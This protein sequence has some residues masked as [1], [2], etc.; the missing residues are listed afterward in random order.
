[1]LRV[2]TGLAKGKRLVCP[3]G[4]VTRPP[5]DFL[6][7]AV[8][9]ILGPR[10]VDASVLD[11]FAGCGAFGIEALS[12]GATICQFVER[13]REALEALRRNL[14]NVHF[15][16][17]AEIGVLDVLKAVKRMSEKPFR[18]DLI[19]VDPPF[20]LLPDAEG[21]AY[22]ESLFVLARGLLKPDGV[23]VLRLPKGK[24]L[25]QWKAAPRDQ[26]SYGESEVFFYGAETAAPPSGT[27]PS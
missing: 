25:E 16:D 7:G 19:F 12:R 9:N 4:R 8:F 23:L 10:V 18:F 17:R 24:D 5:T 22:L 20:A 13:S 2:I 21:R 1:M 15:A 11:L 3:E 6:K 27:D 26:R 14:D